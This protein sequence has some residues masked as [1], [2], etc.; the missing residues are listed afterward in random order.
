MTLRAALSSMHASCN[1]WPATD[2]QP[3]LFEATEGEA[4]TLDYAGPMPSCARCWF[5]KGRSSPPP[6]RNSLRARGQ[7][8]LRVA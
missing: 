7:T 2:E 6:Y 8:A 3:D 5:R 1:R 4:I